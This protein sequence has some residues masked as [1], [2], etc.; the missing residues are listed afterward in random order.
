MHLQGADWILTLDK[1]GE[2]AEDPA[3][4]T[5]IPSVA[6]AILSRVPLAKNGS[7]KIIDRQTKK[8]IKEFT[9][10]EIRARQSLDAISRG[11]Y[12]NGW[13]PSRKQWEQIEKELAEYKI[14]LHRNA[15][16]HID[17]VNQTW[18]AYFHNKTKD[19]YTRAGAT[20]YEVY[21]ELAMRD[22]CNPLER[23]LI[24]S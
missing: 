6:L 12:L 9:A 8:V 20:Y 23:Q 19:I 15:D 5:D 7:L 16:E 11:K 14:T 3:K 2:L 21:H 1:I 18:G 10:E 24:G 17:S 4:I 13:K 22:I